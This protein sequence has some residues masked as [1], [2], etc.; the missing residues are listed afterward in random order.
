M[1]WNIRISPGRAAFFSQV[2]IKWS[3][4]LG[5]TIYHVAITIADILGLYVFIPA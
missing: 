4:M 2:Q 3:K 5:S 1:I